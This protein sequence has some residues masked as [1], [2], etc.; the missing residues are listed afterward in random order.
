MNF[1]RSM[2]EECMVSWTNMSSSLRSN[3]R[4]LSKS[5]SFLSVKGSSIKP[6]SFEHVMTRASTAK[7]VLFG[8]HHEQPSILKAQLCV[9]EGMASQAEEYFKQNQQKQKIF[10]VLEM[11]NFQQQ[12]LLDAYRNYEI[13]IRE[14]EKNYEQDT[15]GFAIMEHYGYLLDTARSLGI[16]VIAG[17]VP[18]SSCK[19]MVSDGKETT[20][21]NIQNIGGPDKSFYVNGSEEHYRYF[22][23]LISGKMDEVNDKYRKIF[24]AQIL[25]DSFFAHSVNKIIQTSENNKVVG[26]CGSGHID[27][28][29]G[30]PERISRKIGPV[31][32]L[33]SR[34]KEDKI[35]PNVADFIYQYE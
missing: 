21:K 4:R 32:L 13:S 20:L 33:T 17:F 15:E 26:I 30:I 1:I 35:D 9:L 24:P 16:T 3:L 10:L 29:F 12:F 14:L 23:G 11:F 5:L 22:Q 2:H 31:L 18:K 25:R 6:C 8:E 34:M 7:V 19:E 27:H 28:G